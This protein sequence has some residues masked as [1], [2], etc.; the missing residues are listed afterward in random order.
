MA[1][2]SYVMEE[3]GAVDIICAGFGANKMCCYCLE[4][5]EMYLSR[6]SQSKANP[7]QCA[8]RHG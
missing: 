3:S 5:L 8:D 4:Y 2:R 1:T 6:R 7:M